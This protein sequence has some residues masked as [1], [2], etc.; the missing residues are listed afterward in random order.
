[1]RHGGTPERLGRR[2]VKTIHR[3]E[4]SLA[5]QLTESVGSTLTLF[6]IDRF[7]VF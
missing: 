2:L 1:M 4:I 3:L 7:L 6:A 5:V